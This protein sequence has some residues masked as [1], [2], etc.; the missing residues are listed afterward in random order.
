MVNII[1]HKGAVIKYEKDGSAIIKS[2]SKLVSSGYYAIFVPTTDEYILN[3]KANLIKGDKAFIY[4][5]DITGK[6]YISRKNIINGKYDK[7]IKFKPENKEIYIGI[8]FWNKNI[9][10]E[11]IVDLFSVKNNDT[12]LNIIQKTIEQPQYTPTTKQ[13]I[14][15]AYTSRSIKAFKDRFMKKYQLHEYTDQKEPVIFFGMY[16][17]RTSEIKMIMSHTGKKIIIF[18]GSDIDRLN[19][20]ENANIVVSNIKKMDNYKIVAISKFIKDDCDY[21]GLKC[22]YIPIHFTKYDNIPLVKKGKCV[23]IYTSPLNDIYYGSRIYNKIIEKMSDVKFIICTG[24]LNSLNEAKRAKVK[25]AENIKYYSNEVLVSVY[26]KCF[27][28]LRLTSHDGNANT[29]TELGIAGIRTVHN[30]GNPSAIGWKY[31]NI[32]FKEN[33][34]DIV[35]YNK[36]LNDTVDD[37]I[38]TIKYEMKSVGTIDNKIREDTLNFIDTSDK[39]LYL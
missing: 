5:E 24:S 15:Y 11:L 39:I 20:K 18:A 30:G 12:T 17:Y 19:Y 33:I 35:E 6:K 13:K 3:I 1:Q 16:A 38:T 31:N 10:Y 29:V 32:L 37:I 36:I 34:D 14:T 22:E 9:E 27:I 4:C 7:S 2:K 23:Y 26:K 28:G 21:Y 8:L 25:G